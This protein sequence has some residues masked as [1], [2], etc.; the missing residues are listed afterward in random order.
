MTSA[1]KEGPTKDAK[2]HSDLELI[3]QCLAGN[4]SA[5]ESLI[6]RYKRL[7]VSIPYGYG[8]SEEDCS[9]I[10]QA[11]CMDLLSELARLRERKAL[12]GWLIQVTRNKCFHRKHSLLRRRGIETSTFEVAS[13][14]GEPEG[15]VSQLEKQH[16]LQQALAEASPQCQELINMLFFA[17]PP[18]PYVEVAQR[19]RL[20]RGSIGFARRDCL[21]KLR[22]R[23]EQLGY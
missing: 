22:D 7:I 11:V 5:W 15:L 17:T 13:C 2:Q 16:I 10:F 9:D 23:L 6:D 1:P 14:S 19:L 20:A 12:A 4:E 8:F 21:D 18:R 3:D